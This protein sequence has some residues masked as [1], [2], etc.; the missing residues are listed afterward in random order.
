MTGEVMIMPPFWPLFVVL[1]VGVVVAVAL[2]VGPRLFLDTLTVRQ[3]FWCVFQRRR[4]DV[5]FQEAVWDGCPID[6]TRCSAFDP[7]TAVT[8]DKAC[9]KLSPEYRSSR[10]A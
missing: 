10:V 3:S 7:P 5:D 9:L 8:C 1:A 6:V 2:A 4:V